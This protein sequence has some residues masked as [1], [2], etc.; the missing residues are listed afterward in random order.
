MFLLQSVTAFGRAMIDL[1]KQHVEEMYTIKNGY[2][3]DAKVFLFSIFIFKL[4]IYG[5]LNFLYLFYYC[6]LV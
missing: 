2:K 1:T 3:H 6:N 5:L 4:Y